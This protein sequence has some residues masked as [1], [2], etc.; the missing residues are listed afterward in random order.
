VADLYRSEQTQPSHQYCQLHQNHAYS[1][2]YADSCYN[3]KA[4]GPMPLV[5]SNQWTLLLT[6]VR[7]ADMLEQFLN[8]IKL[9]SSNV[10]ELPLKVLISTRGQS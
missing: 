10:K 3:I 9:T 5:S 4:N 8:A 2:I 1:L 6:F 7:T